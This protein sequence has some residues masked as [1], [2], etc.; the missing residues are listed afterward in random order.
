MPSNDEVVLGI[1]SIQCPSCRY[2]LDLSGKPIEKFTKGQR[3]RAEEE[4]RNQCSTSTRTQ[5]AQDAEDLPSSAPQKVL[6]VV[7]CPNPHCD[8]YNKIKVMELPRIKTPSAKVDLG[9]E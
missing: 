7:T 1:P 5:R 6:I 9:D 8:Q 2:V 4:S 3:R